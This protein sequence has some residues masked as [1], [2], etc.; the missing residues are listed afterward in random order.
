MGRNA[1]RFGKYPKTFQGL[2]AEEA[3]Q[4]FSK[5]SDGDI[6]KWVDE[7]NGW[8]GSYSREEKQ[9]LFKELAGKLSGENLARF[10]KALGND[11]FDSGDLG[12]AIAQNSSSQAKVDFVKNMAGSVEQ[13]R[14]AS[15]RLPK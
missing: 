14:G 3:N 1:R 7:L 2:N 13:N 8:N 5:L 10:A 11:G 9:Q 12:R 4:V 15:K 6:K